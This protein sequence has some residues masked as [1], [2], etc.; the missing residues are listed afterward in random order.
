[1]LNLARENNEFKIQLKNTEN[2]KDFRRK[3]TDK[4]E[5]KD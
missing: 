3:F 5:E 1:M 2:D 4:L